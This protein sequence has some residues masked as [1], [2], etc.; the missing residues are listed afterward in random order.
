MD[1]GLRKLVTDDV[2][3]SV[4]TLGEIDFVLAAKDFAIVHVKWGMRGDRNDDGT[5]R[6]PREGI[7]TWTTVRAG[8]K[9]KIRASHNSNNQQIR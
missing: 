8:D 3:E 6:E 5:A 7:S 4:M 9:W 1:P 2:K